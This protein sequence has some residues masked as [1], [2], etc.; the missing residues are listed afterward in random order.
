M[1]K[2]ESKRFGKILEVKQ[3]DLVQV[4]RN[5]DGIAIEN[6]PD[7][8]DAVQ[9]ASERELAICNLAREFSLLKDVRAALR[10]LEEGTFGVCLR[11]EADISSKRLSAV[12]WAALCI[13][14]QE[15]A[16]SGSGEDNSN[17]P[18]GEAA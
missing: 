9:F 12:P 2:N 3:K 13:G 1:T 14:C 11:C 4:M 17:Q 6:S 15:F 16:D 5:R 18:L 10:R 7:S 8:F